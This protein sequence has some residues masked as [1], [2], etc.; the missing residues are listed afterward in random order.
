MCHDFNGN[1]ELANCPFKV[2]SMAL[3]EHGISTHP[4]WGNEPFNETLSKHTYV[5]V[6]NLRL[7]SLHWHFDSKPVPDHNHS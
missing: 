5:I 3:N 6:F 7:D 4:C 2:L 1:E